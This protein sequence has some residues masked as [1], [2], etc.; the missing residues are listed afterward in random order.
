MSHAVVI[1][2]KSTD[3]AGSLPTLADRAV[4][5]LGIDRFPGGLEVYCVGPDDAARRYALAACA[6]R[7]NVL[8][9]LQVVR[10]EW[11]LVGPGSLADFGDWLP[12]ALAER[13]AAALVFDIQD[14]LAVEGNTLTVWRDLGSGNRD[15]LAITGPAVLV[16]APWLVPTRYVS[17]FRQRAVQAVPVQSQEAGLPN[18][19]QRL[20]GDWEPVRPRV[21]LRAAVP[22]EPTTAEDR[23][24]RAF[25]LGADTEDS[26]DAS[27]PLQADPATCAAHLLR[28]LRHHGLLPRSIPVALSEAEILPASGTLELSPPQFVAAPAERSVSFMTRT[29]RLI[30]EVAVERHTRQPRRAEGPLPTAP[31]PAAVSRRPRL[32]GGLAPERRRGPRRIH[33]DMTI[34]STR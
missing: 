34:L 22:G 24:N 3:L 30:G 5:E 17:R 1:I 7:V 14:I 27:Q 19:L 9:D 21:Q 8:S 23:A 31:F 15:E 25:G 32:V 13:L 10:A 12:A 16:F 20:V 26:N 11:V 29:P 33:S 18:P 2:G 28:Y 4:L 6:S